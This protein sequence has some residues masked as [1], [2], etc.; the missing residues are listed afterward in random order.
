MSTISL[1]RQKKNQSRARF[2]YSRSSHTIRRSTRHKCQM[3]VRVENS[4]MLHANNCSHKSTFSAIKSRCKQDFSCG[5]IHFEVGLLCERVYRQHMR[6]QMP[7]CDDLCS[8]QATTLT[9]TFKAT[10]DNH[11]FFSLAF[12]PLSN[13]CYYASL[14]N[15]AHASSTSNFYF[16]FLQLTYFYF[17]LRLFIFRAEWVLYTTPIIII[18]LIMLS[19]MCGYF[20]NTHTHNTHH[21]VFV[22]PSW[23]FLVCDAYAADIL[24]VWRWN[25]MCRIYRAIWKTCIFFRNLQTN[26]DEPDR[27]VDM[28]KNLQN[29]LYCSFVHHAENDFIW[30]LC[31]DTL[32]VNRCGHGQNV[33]G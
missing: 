18:I 33:K 11:C 10:S 4:L 5:G 15:K 23:I 25:F 29:K 30:S 32:P 21:D 12:Y 2:T 22:R 3:L 28:R 26:L 27:P 6:C 7:K 9:K 17:H 20:H 14:P 24:N 8:D 1:M 13:K 19:E 16:F 31:V